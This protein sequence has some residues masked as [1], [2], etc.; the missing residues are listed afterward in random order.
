MDIMLPKIKL[1]SLKTVR[2][3]FFLQNQYTKQSMQKIKF[4]K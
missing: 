2:R 1:M 3:N 4:T